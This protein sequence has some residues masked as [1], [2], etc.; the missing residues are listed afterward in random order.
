MTNLGLGKVLGLDLSST[1]GFCWGRPGDVP[2]WGARILPKQDGPGAV[3]AALEDWLDE[4]LAVEKPDV[5]GYEAPLP[6][7]L[8]GDREACIY[9]YGLTF[10]AE[11]CA[12][13]AGIPCRAHSLDTLRGAVIGRTRLT[14]E[15]KAIRPRVSVKNAIIAP[16]VRSQGWDITDPDSRDAAVV[17]AYICGIRHAEFRK[18]R[19]A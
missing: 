10:A 9:A 6:P 13:R 15:E 11:A 1:V 3:C 12:W 8:Q 18:R 2:R 14:D 7:M 16:W 19:A 4:F 5:I 17:W